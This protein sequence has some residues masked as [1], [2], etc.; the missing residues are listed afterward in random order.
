MTAPPG[1]GLIKR[2]GDFPA[3]R[4]VAP[5]ALTSS[6]ATVATNYLCDGRDLGRRQHVGRPAASC[7]SLNRL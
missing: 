5:T 1:R 3:T 2:G 4:H 7:C 6:S